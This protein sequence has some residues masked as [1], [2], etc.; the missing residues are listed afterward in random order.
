MQQNARDASGFSTLELLISLAIMSVVIIQTLGLFVSQQQTFQ[1][2]QRVVAAQ[3]DSRLAA[4]MMHRDVRMAGF[5]VAAFA[6]ISS[7]D[8]DTTASDVL[9]VSDPSVLDATKIDEATEPFDR[10]VITP[11]AVVGGVSSVTISANHADVDEDGNDDFEIDHGII[12]SDGSQ[13]WCAHVTSVGATSIGFDPPTPG[14]F[15]VA[16]TTGRA[17]PA[18]IYQRTG[19][20][21]ERNK[22]LLSREVE[23]VQVAF[24][25]DLD[26]NGVI[27]GAE[28]PIHDIEVV[29]TNQIQE[30][31]VSVL[32]RTR[33]EDPRLTGNG[34]QKV[35]NRAASGTPD[36]YRRRLSVVRAAPRTLN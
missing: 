1:V 13:T 21:L 3:E 9:C 12:I 17:V 7:R 24:G 6:G 30:V 28:F 19:V 2:Q 10:A 35:A 14:G 18:V 20:G 31:R 32:T 4:D 26:D 16:A 36:A 23:D 11:T 5:M 27:A 33:T 15:A 29:D 25:L 22:K 8:G 34:R